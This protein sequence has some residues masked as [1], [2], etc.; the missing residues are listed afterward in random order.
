MKKG[1]LEK[2]YPLPPPL[3]HEQLAFSVTW[4][5]SWIISYTENLDGHYS[6]LNV[7]SSGRLCPCPT[8]PHRGEIGP[9]HTL[10]PSQHLTLG[11]CRVTS[12]KVSVISASRIQRSSRRLVALSFC[13]LLDPEFLGY[14][15]K[16]WINENGYLSTCGPAE[17][18]GCVLCNCA[19]GHTMWK[20][21]WILKNNNNNNKKRTTASFIIEFIFQCI[22]RTRYCCAEWERQKR[23]VVTWIITLSTPPPLLLLTSDRIKGESRR[24]KESLCE[25]PFR[26]SSLGRR[27]S[28][29]KDFV[30]YGFGKCAIQ[31]GLVWIP[32][33][34]QKISFNDE[35]RWK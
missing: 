1:C 23:K 33:Q 10:Y 17:A 22:C 34:T 28:A 6:G 5:L 26:P 27:Q 7:T 25:S 16:E 35:E 2:S 29:N 20:H 9:G 24:T 32:W 11:D 4:I 3:W 8:P 13:S 30:L 21:G 14:L 19:Y 12:E 31:R 15:F 18:M